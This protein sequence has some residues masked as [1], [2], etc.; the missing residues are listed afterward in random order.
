MPRKRLPCEWPDPEGRCS[1]E[2]ACGFGCGKCNRHCKQEP[3]DHRRKNDNGSNDISCAGPRRTSRDNT[4]EKISI[5][6]ANKTPTKM[7]LA[8]TDY[9]SIEDFSFIEPLSKGLTPR[10]KIDGNSS[11]YLFTPLIRYGIAIIL[12]LGASFAATPCAIGFVQKRLLEGIAAKQEEEGGEQRLKGKALNVLHDLVE[13]L[14]VNK[15]NNQNGDTYLSVGSVVAHHLSARDLVAFQELDNNISESELFTITKYGRKKLNSIYHKVTT[16]EK[17]DEDEDDDDGA[18]QFGRHSS[19][20][21]EIVEEAVRFI[22]D[23]CSL[24]SWGVKR[25]PDGNGDTLEIPAMTRSCNPTEMYENYFEFKEKQ[26]E[27]FV[28][29]VGHDG[30]LKREDPR[31][32]NSVYNLHLKW[33][34]GSVSPVSLHNIAVDDMASCAVYG[35]KNDL[36]KKEG[37]VRIG[38]SVERKMAGQSKMQRTM[39]AFRHRRNMLGR[40]SFKDL[41]RALTNGDEKMI[42]AVDYVR[43]ELVHNPTDGIQQLIEDVVDNPAHRK[44]LTKKVTIVSN[45]LKNQFKAHIGEDDVPSSAGTHGLVHSL[46]VPPMPPNHYSTMAGGDITRLLEERREKLMSQGFDLPD[47]A[48]TKVAKIVQLEWFDTRDTG[49]VLED[50]PLG[51]KMGDDAGENAE[52]QLLTATT[53]SNNTTGSEDSASTNTTCRSFPPKTEE[54]AQQLAAM[55][56]DQ[57]RNEIKQQGLPIK[58]TSKAVLVDC[59]MKHFVEQIKQQT[60]TSPEGPTPGNTINADS[61]GT[62]N[63]GDGSTLDSS[64]ENESVSSISSSGGGSEE[65]T[66]DQ[67]PAANLAAYIREALAED[68]SLA[69]VQ[70]EMT[71]LNIKDD[72]DCLGCFFLHYFMLD[73]LPKVLAKYRNEHNNAQIDDALEFILDSHEKFMIY[74]AHVA[75]TVNQS[76]ELSKMNEQLKAKCRADQNLSPKDLW[77]IIDFKMKWEAMYL[78]EKTTQNFA[79]RGTSWHGVYIYYYQWDPVEEMPVKYVSKMDQILDGTNEQSG[80]TVIALVEAMMAY[81]GH[82]FEGANISFLQSDNANYY[83]TKE[84]VLF[85]PQMNN[86][87]LHFLCLLQYQFHLTLFFTTNRERRRLEGR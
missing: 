35:L 78:R 72:D 19:I 9:R 68:G 34:D 39:R 70:N 82:E 2:S 65:A 37:W 52:D 71:M 10:T 27:A 41:V 14:K 36:L 60:C 61:D 42:T 25:V 85:I 62:G 47:K 59:L 20:S 49:V 23:Q 87:S 8:D 67:A 69:E 48:K 76:N 73:E 55:K 80:L 79:K 40:T 75:R 44:S 7:K 74:Q 58:S 66:H 5:A 77:V 13:V 22:V 26:K 24:L 64:V 21:D 51:D 18:L 12:K 38:A 1:K 81:I 54:Y 11:R 30:P 31:Y 33:A 57:L 4:D 28:D 50:G 17:G 6:A 56:I 83:H 3:C 53:G 45:F 15:A 46:T 16:G 32:I 84:L 86:V 29:I 63:T 43:G